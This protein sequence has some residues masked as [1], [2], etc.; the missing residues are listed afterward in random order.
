MN[1]AFS[2]LRLLQR[3]LPLLFSAAPLDTFLLTLVLLLQ[4]LMPTATLFLTKATVDGV[5][6]L[7]RG[8]GD[9]PVL[10]LTTSWVSLL[11]LGTLLAPINQVLQ[12]NVAE[13]F[14]AYVNIQLMRKAQALPGLDLIEDPRFYDDLQLLQEGAKNRP[15]NLVVML[16]FSLR[17]AITLLSLV[18]LLTALAW[19]VPLAILLAAFPQA[20]MSLRLREVGWQ[21]LI[22]RSPDARIMEYDSRVA[23]THA[24]A[25][26]VRLY[27]LFEWLQARYMNRFSIS[28]AEMRRVRLQQA[29]KVI[30]TSLFSVAVVGA[31][32]TWAMWRASQ[33][34]LSVGEVVL[35]VQGLGQMQLYAG[36]L[37][38]NV[39][40]LYERA[41]YFEKYFTFLEAEPTVRL[42]AQ[43][44]PLPSGRTS[45][46]FEK[47]TFAY[48]DGR[49]ALSD[50]TFSLRAG[51][52]V[53]I[54]GENG[55]GKTTLVK[56]LL[57]FYDPTA[58]RVSVS[59]VDLKQ[60]DLNA[61]R[62]K[63]SAV[64]QDFG[65]YAY[66]VR[67]N[68]VLADLS[69]ADDQDALERAV[70]HAGFASVMARLTQGEETLLGKEFGGTDLSGG[71]WQKLAVARALFRDS[72]VLVLDE[73]TA[74]LDPRSEHELFSRFAA[75]S[76]GR[77]TILITH[78]LASVRMADRVLVFKHG[79]LVEDGS[80]AALLAK[81]GE[82]AELWHLQAEKYADTMA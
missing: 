31:L 45:V 14:T 48:P 3:S 47:V 13:K 74:A 37:I 27:N 62:S 63:I 75:L 64:F 38:E 2:F 12:G 16:V 33:G 21:A 17:D 7:A 1:T 43:A 36:S 41:L 18:G 11:L 76:Q 44:L 9:V 67:D 40:V 39:G 59:G 20:R 58:G 72:E 53:A 8:V 29:A 60:L 10:V 19:W 4:G 81:G 46:A 25:Q 71:Q 79:R 82:Y 57:R 26:E 35:V 51:E 54:V 73:P 6:N 28:H 78:R 30:P 52:T 77:T 42:P 49:V 32:F 55:A 23:L 22:S 61:W 24:F 68:I 65:R 50:V 5:S 69:K 80:H 66:R 15:L 34:L 70:A 56:L